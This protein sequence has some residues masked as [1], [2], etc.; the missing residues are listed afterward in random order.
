MTKRTERIASFPDMGVECFAKWDA[1]LE[2]YEV[3]TKEN[4]EGYIGSADTIREAKRVARE[5]FE[6]LM[7]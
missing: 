4:G 6:G 3:V 5:F 7:A 1:E 2:L